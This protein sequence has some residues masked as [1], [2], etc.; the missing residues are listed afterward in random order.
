MIAIV[1]WCLAADALI[2]LV[3]GLMSLFEPTDQYK[4]P[5]SPKPRRG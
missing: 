2:L 4:A 3:A 1:L 5:A